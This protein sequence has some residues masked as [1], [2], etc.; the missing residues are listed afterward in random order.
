MNSRRKFLNNLSVLLFSGAA[1]RSNTGIGQEQFAFNDDGYWDLVRAQFSFEESTVPMNAA[2][3]CPSFRSVSNAVSSLT[4]DIDKDCSFNNRSKFG[5]FLEESRDIIARQLNVDSDEIALVRNT[6]EANNIINNGLTLSAGDEVVLWDQN[7]PTNNIAWSVRAERLGF[8]VKRVTS[9]ALP[10]SEQELLDLFVSHFSANT[11][12][13][14]LTYVSNTS[15]VKLPI[16]AIASAA[17]ARGI[18]VHVDGAQVWGAM[19]LDLNELGI[20]SFSASSH[21]WLMGPK[22]VGLLYINRNNIDRIWPNI[23]SAGWGNESAT[24]LKG[25]R[26]FESLGQRN[27]SALAAV[28][29]TVKQLELI[30][31]QRIEARTVELSQLLKEGVVEAG[32]EL[33]TPIDPILSHGVC[34]MEVPSEKRSEIVDSLYQNFGIAGAP[35]GG[36]RLCPAIYNTKEHV[37]RAIAAVQQLLG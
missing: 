22:E 33:I 18:Y 1:T 20:D 7:H 4:Q 19:P 5:I 29:T 21:K 28:G 2:N 16:K 11:K 25:A 34:I 30:G 13:V 35:T 37:E 23:I 3:L 32:I 14:A 10:K 17:R 36:L 8:S 15:G 31:L 24:H 12:V 6:S 26:K 27:D 9:P